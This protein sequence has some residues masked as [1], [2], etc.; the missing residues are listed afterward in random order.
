MRVTL[1]TFKADPELHD[2]IDGILSSGRLSYG[3]YSQTLEDEFA[4]YCGHRYG[5]LSNS[6][7]SSLVVALLAAKEK[8]GWTKRSEVI[9]PATTFVAS[10]NAVLHAGLTPRLVDID[11]ERW[12]FGYDE[13]ADVRNSYTVAVMAVNLFGKPS[14]LRSIRKACDDFDL[15]M[16]EDSCEAVGAMHFGAP[17]GSYGDISVFSFY[18][19]HI[20]T[21]GVGGIAV[22]SN[23]ELALLM[24][25]Y[26]NHG[27]SVAS[28]HPGDYDAGFLG[29]KFLFDRIGHSYRITELEAAI[30][31]HELRKIDRIL[32]GRNRVAE[33]YTESLSFEIGSKEIQVA[34]YRRGETSSWMMY[35]IVLSRMSKHKMMAVLRANDIEVRDLVPLTYQPCYDI[36]H[37]EYPNAQ[38][39]NTDGFYIGCHEDMTQDQVS[40]ATEIIQ[41]VLAWEILKKNLEIN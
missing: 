41:E 18:M 33:W 36:D 27:L 29:R 40:Y 4:Q 17:V 8:Y 9:V 22:T 21:A 6:G 32:E 11:P 1:G 10:Y 2:T 24:R 37:E 13:V 20:I 28:L 23:E 30:A 12:D 26:V 39:L 35:P 16:I 7:T 3:P 34:S 19:A 5:V 25:S 38:R 14:Q 31:L 15:F